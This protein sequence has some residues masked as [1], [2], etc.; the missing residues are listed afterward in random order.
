MIDSLLSAFEQLV[1]NSMLTHVQQC[2]EAETHRVKNSDEW[3]LSLSK[4][5]KSFSFLAVCTRSIMW[6]ESTDS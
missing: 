1:D 4:L 3:K 5:T 2:T 6:K